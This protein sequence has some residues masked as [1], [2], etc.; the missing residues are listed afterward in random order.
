[1]SLLEVISTPPPVSSAASMTFS[2]SMT[3][4]A[5]ARLFRGLALV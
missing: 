2:S 3:R 5:G 1:V 4:L